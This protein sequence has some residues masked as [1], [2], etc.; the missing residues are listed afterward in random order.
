MSSQGSSLTP[1]FLLSFEQVNWVPLSLWR[2]EILRYA[3]GKKK[4]KTKQNKTKNV[5]Y[6]KHHLFRMNH[7]LGMN[8]WLLQENL[9]AK[10]HQSCI[11]FFFLSV[12]LYHNI[13]NFTISSLLNCIPKKTFK[14]NAIPPLHENSKR[15]KGRL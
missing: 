6:C 11:K 14:K 3:E 12:Q 2:N 13:F 10:S 7:M 5:R 15:I 4:T 9:T 1:W 8:R